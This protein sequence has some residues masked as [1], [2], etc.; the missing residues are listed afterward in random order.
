MPWYRARPSPAK[1]TWRGHQRQSR[2]VSEN[3][4][5]L[6]GGMMK[7]GG[8]CDCKCLGNDLSFL[9]HLFVLTFVSVPLVFLCTL[10]EVVAKTAVDLARWSGEINLPPDTRERQI[11]HTAGL[12]MGRL[13]DKALFSLLGCFCRCICSNSVLDRDVVSLV[14]PLL[15]Q[16]YVA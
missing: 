5:E 11:Q 3:S 1:T 6:G 13:L 4:P 10:G 7:L 16:L 12:G 2:N 14:E 15:P 9:C 8:L